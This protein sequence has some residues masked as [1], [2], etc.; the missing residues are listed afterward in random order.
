MRADFQRTVEAKEKKWGEMSAEIE[1][2]KKDF[3]LFTATHTSNLHSMWNTKFLELAEK[4]EKLNRKSGELQ[5]WEERLAAV[6]QNFDHLK[7]LLANDVEMEDAA[8]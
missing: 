7:Q 3:Y 6:E 4:E 2:L 5:I 1:R 8:N